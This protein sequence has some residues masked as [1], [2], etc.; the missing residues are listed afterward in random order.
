MGLVDEED[1]NNL[2]IDYEISV[3]QLYT[4][5]TMYWLM[6]PGSMFSSG[7][8]LHRAFFPKEI[9]FLPSWVPDWTSSLKAHTNPKADRIPV[10]QIWL[11]DISGGN[12]SSGLRR[13]G[14]SSA[15]A[16]SDLRPGWSLDD[17][18]WHR[19]CSADYYWGDNPEISHRYLWRKFAV[20]AGWDPKSSARPLRASGML[21][22][23]VVH[24]LSISKGEVILTDAN[25]KLLHGLYVAGLDRSSLDKTDMQLDETHLH[26]LLNWRRSLLLQRHRD[27]VYSLNSPCRISCTSEGPLAD[28]RPHR[29]GSDISTHLGSLE[30]GILEIWLV[31]VF[32]FGARAGAAFATSTRRSIIQ[33]GWFK[34]LPLASTVCAHAKSLPDCYVT[35]VHERLE[36]SAMTDLLNDIMA[37][38]VENEVNSFQDESQ[39]I[40]NASPEDQ[41]MFESFVRPSFTP[42]PT[43]TLDAKLTA[44]IKRAEAASLWRALS[45]KETIAYLKGVV[46]LQRE[47]CKK[48]Q[49][50]ETAMSDLSGSLIQPHIAVEMQTSAR[51]T[52]YGPQHES[53][54]FFA[55]WTLMRPVLYAEPLPDGNTKFLLPERRIIKDAW[56]LLDDLTVDAIYSLEQNLAI[57]WIHVLTMEMVVRLRGIFQQRLILKAIGDKMRNVQSVY[58]I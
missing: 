35:G 22:T 40:K 56:A 18:F 14:S 24:I 33:S 34:Y 54:H 47:A 45:T 20:D 58:L 44:H 15:I 19:L 55:L 25:G 9:P 37:F 29:T 7:Y 43:E 16:R 26:V 46:K 50:L 49:P 39:A 27:G 4:G 21:A 32:F 6:K 42:S 41:V 13:F 1:R 31:N 8:I 12:N 52:L 53:E 10:A 11:H 48:Y 5:L 57:L 2:P 3:Q 23:D 51:M 28:I 38:F 36:L 17:N 30:I